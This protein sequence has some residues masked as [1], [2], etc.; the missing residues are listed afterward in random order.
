[1]DNNSPGLPLAFPSELFN[2]YTNLSCACTLSDADFKADIG[3][4]ESKPTINNKPYSYKLETS[5]ETG[6]EWI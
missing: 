5:L 4:T 6:R 3:I 1:M 2:S